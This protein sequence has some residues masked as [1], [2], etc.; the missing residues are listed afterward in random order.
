MPREIIRWLISVDANFLADLADIA[1]GSERSDVAVH[2]WAL[3]SMNELHV[4]DRE[5]EM[6]DIAGTAACVLA[7]AQ[8]WVA[9]GP[10]ASELG[11]KLPPPPALVEA[12][13]NGPAVMAQLRRKGVTCIPVTPLEGKV[14]RVVGAGPTDAA[15]YGR[16]A[17]F[18]DDALA[19]KI[20]LPHPALVIEGRSFAWSLDL[21]HKFAQFPR[22]GKDDTDAASQAWGHLMVH[23]WAQEEREAQRAAQA[24]A[25]AV[26][27]A[28]L[29]PGSKLPETTHEIVAAKRSQAMLEAIRTQQQ[30]QRQQ[31]RGVW[32][33]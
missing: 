19:G 9:G 14:S 24:E 30:R 29:P 17:S 25:K 18:A 21:R 6:Y 11:I 2:L 4:L 22:G 7:M 31:S 16:A 26:K 12:K 13:A 10:F 20:H 5:L 8:R 1:K 15:K 23:G 32:R 33:R 3:D 27:N 28:G